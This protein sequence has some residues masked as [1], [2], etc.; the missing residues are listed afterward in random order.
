MNL[1]ILS[2]GS[3]PMPNFITA[4]YLLCN[5]RDESELEKLPKPDKILFVYSSGTEKFKNSIIHKLDLNQNRFIEVNLEDK[6]REF[7]HI[8][9]RVLSKIKCVAEKQSITSIHLNYTGGTKPMAVGISAAVELFDKCEN[10]IYSDLSPDRFKFILHTNEEFPTNDDIR[11]IVNIKI[12]DL[13][14]LHGLK[15]PKL[16]KEN[17]KRYSDK[18]I[19]FLIEQ[20]EKHK[21]GDGGFLDLW[22]K[23]PGK[24]KAKKNRQEFK[25]QS[26]KYTN[27]STEELNNKLDELKNKLKSSVKDVINNIDN[28]TWD[29]KKING[30]K[31]FICGLWLEEYLFDV[32]KEI[33]DDCGLTD[34]AWNVETEIKGRLFELDV[35]A[36]KGCQSFVFTCTTDYGSGLCKGKAFEGVYRSEQIGGEHSKTVLVCMADDLDKNGKQ[37]DDIGQK[38]IENIKKDM[39][40]F[41]AAENFYILGSEEIKCRSEFKDR[42]IKIIN[43]DI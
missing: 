32:L 40:Q 19:K 35:I 26:D 5:E 15:R 38:V 42:L 22:K 25:K 16:K 3:N 30:L 24:T 4:A 18:F 31:K 20:K 39:S 10:K 2:V 6:F 28:T 14:E 23:W 27:L 21:R 33:K 9:D 43:G 17:N 37:A 7:N 34:I 11:N 13:Y 36:M 8:K 41:D 29:L 12:E 1:L